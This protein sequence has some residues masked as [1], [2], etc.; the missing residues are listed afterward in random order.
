MPGRRPWVLAS[1]LT[2][3]VVVVALV[4]YLLVR[5]DPYVAPPPTGSAARPDPAGAA[6]ALQ[7]LQSAITSRDADSAAALAP[8]SDAPAA[9]LLKAVVANADA[10]DVV[11]FTARYVDDVGAVDPA[12]HWQAAVDLTWRFGGFDKEPVHEEV[13]V[14]FQ[15]E[16]GASPDGD[17]GITSFGGGDRRSPLWLS[18]PVEVRRSATSLVLATTAANADLLAGRAEAAVP[19]VRDV[20]PQW[21]GKLVVE[22]P[23]SEEGLDAVLAAEPGSYTDIAAV[24]ASVD[25]TITPQS[26]VHV[27]VNPDVYDE[28]EPVGGQ[29][30]ISH[31]ATHLATGAPLTTGVPLW[32]LEG[33]ADYVALHAVDL[34]ITTTAAQ[35]I[36]QVRR[37]G[38][39]D[40][41]PGQAEFD[42]TA[43]HL[44][45]AYESAWVACLVL[46]D[47]GGRAALVRLYEQVS[48]GHDLDGQ[49]HEL[50]GLTEAELTTRWR[51]R[52]MDLAARSSDGA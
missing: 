7:E 49:L 34:P 20:L 27:F 37:D 31:E 46:A 26:E 12:G 36:Q 5:S 38:A 47:A 45:A 13:L 1:A 43:T 35:I 21:N 16:R 6:H 30:V 51:Q 8:T 29:V 39:P 52:L 44:G 3:L 18:G 50:F 19:V 23:A 48:R 17:V 28:L 4:T 9:D 10:L 14:A 2:A 15:L 22:V 42:E 33:F 11:E 32:L 24:T 41:L 25:G 40:Q